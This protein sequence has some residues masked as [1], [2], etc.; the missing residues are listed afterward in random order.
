MKRVRNQ[1]GFTLIE[2]LV[3]LVIIGIL[4]AI[5]LTRYQDLTLE[6]QIGATKGNLGTIRGG[7]ALLHAKFL[8]AGYGG[9][10]LEYPTVMELN[11]N[12]TSGRSAVLNGLK[13]IDGPSN[14]GGSPPCIQCMPPNS[15]ISNS[16]LV[17]QVTT[18]QADSRSVSGG[19]GTGWDYDPGTGQIFVA[20]TIPTDSLG[21]GANLW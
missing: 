6:A 10:A 1:K 8:L 11:N 17:V 20:A 18:I 3:V 12:L 9:T 5:A 21:T 14:L 4:S 2:L 19:L 15:V 7:I 16:R 13:I